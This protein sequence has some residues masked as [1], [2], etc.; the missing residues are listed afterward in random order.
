MTVWGR[1]QHPD[2]SFHQYTAGLLQLVVLW[3]SRWFDEPRVVSSERRGTSHPRSQAMRSHHDSPTS[4]ALAAS[5]QKVVSR[6]PPLCVTHWLA[7]LLC[8]WLTN[9]RWLPPLLGR[10]PLWQSNMLSQE[11]TQPVRWPLFCH[12]QANAVEQSAWTDSA[13]GHHLRTIQTI[14]ENVSVW[15]VGPRRPVS[16]R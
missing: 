13:T 8:T 12:R 11:I 4:A 15:L 5:S 9:V 1:R 16:E 6:Y 3:H 7:P 14:V 2:P 10:R